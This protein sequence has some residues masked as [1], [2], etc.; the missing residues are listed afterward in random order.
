MSERHALITGAGMVGTSAA[1]ELLAD[2]WQVTL[3]DRQMPHDYVNEVLGAA[4]LDGRV[5]LVEVDLADG[6]ARE[7]ALAGIRVDAVVHTA[8]LIAARAQRDALETL[9]VNVEV[10]LWLA[11]W[12]S[13]A[14]A[15][16]FVPISSW[17]VFSE[18]QPGPIVDDSPLTTQFVSHYTA[19]KLAMEHLLSAY[20]SASGLEVVVLRPTVVYGY[21]PNLGGSVGSAAIEAQV[22]RAVRGEAVE[23]PATVISTTELVHVADVGRA[24]AA[25]V[26]VPLEGV[27]TSYVVGSQETTT[28][29]ELAATLRELFPEVPVTIGAGDPSSVVPPKQT[30]PT[31]LTRTIAELG[32]PVPVRRREGFALFAEE[33]RAS[34]AVSEVVR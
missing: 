8:A 9:S 10:P 14:G 31:D 33:L 15:T 12:A 34:A 28:I 2:G 7:T 26:R 27:F 23:L 21:G 20:A 6:Q 30:Q 16:R 3:V 13:R 1:R 17:S 5:A 19:S 32:V 25:A 24:A 18:Q 11:A 29:E 22:L 4:A